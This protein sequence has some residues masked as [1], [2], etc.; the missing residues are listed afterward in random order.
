MNADSSV[1]IVLQW[2]AFSEVRVSIFSA[3]LAFLIWVLASVYYQDYRV[4]KDDAEHDGDSYGARASIKD[5]PAS[6]RVPVSAT[7]LCGYLSCVVQLWVEKLT[8]GG[9]QTPGDK[10]LSDSHVK[11][12]KRWKDEFAGILHYGSLWKKI[13]LTIT[14]ECWSP[15]FRKSVKSQNVQQP[16]ALDCVFL[17]VDLVR[18]CDIELKLM[19]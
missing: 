19:P 6:D 5:A 18:S 14:I 4:E 9:R 16:V 15:V 3:S 13:E 17:G 2:A 8:I 12:S 7:L 10:I 11:W 1:T